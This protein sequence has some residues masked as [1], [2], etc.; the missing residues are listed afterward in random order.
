MNDEV[1]KL[2]GELQWEYQRMSSS[3]QK[4]YNE[5]CKILNIK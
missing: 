4:T 3:G 1:K 2:I 5:I